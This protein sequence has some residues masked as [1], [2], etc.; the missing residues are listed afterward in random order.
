MA[1]RNILL[2]ITFPNA[3]QC[4]VTDFSLLSLSTW[5]ANVN[6]YVSTPTC[7]ASDFNVGSSFTT[8]MGSGTY[9]IDANKQGSSNSSVVRL[10]MPG[11]STEYYSYG[12]EFLTSSYRWGYVACVNDETQRGFFAML[13]M[14]TSNNNIRWWAGSV[15]PLPTGVGDTVRSKMYT[16][17][18]NNERIIYDWQSVMS[19]SGDDKTYMLSK[20]F[21][22]N[23][24]EPVNNVSVQGNLSLASKTA[25]NVLIDEVVLDM[26]KVKV[27]YS[28]P[29]G[30]YLYIKLVYKRGSVPTSV[31][32]G[33]AIT[34]TQASTEQII[35]GIAD[36]GTYWFV[37]FTDVSK[38]LPKSI[39]TEQTIIHILNARAED[40][41]IN[42]G[43]YYEE[44]SV[45][46]TMGYYDSTDDEMYFRWNAKLIYYIGPNSADIKRASKIII[47][48]CARL[49]GR[50]WVD[51]MSISFSE[52]TNPL[53]AMLGYG[54]DE[55][56]FDMF[57]INNH[58]FLSGEGILN[59]L[60]DVDSDLHDI[61]FELSLNHSGNITIPTHLNIY[62]DNNLY[63]QT[64][65]TGESWNF[66]GGHERIEINIMAQSWV[67]SFG[68]DLVF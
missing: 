12:N 66:G 33:T 37:I 14:S 22:I 40:E 51:V 10:Y 35:D 47:S 67:R 24:G 18:T 5:P 63:R 25:V 39:T 21:N 9:R 38:S 13:L 6:S 48:G 36:G 32:D 41:F 54:W 57:K 50:A 7:V 59:N 42:H 46:G 43:Y 17:L 64:D 34:I 62:V 29:N 28:I 27:T 31:S 4:E 53:D 56:N 58:S 61:R 1:W 23:D 52:Y 19:I 45:S 65:I 8:V 55:S 2:N 20:I 44:P 3:A 68:M 26:S 15:P 16:L 60:Y 11:L 49:T 30:T